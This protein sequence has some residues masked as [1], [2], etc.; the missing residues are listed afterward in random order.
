MLRVTGAGLKY[1]SVNVCVIREPA[2]DTEETPPFLCGD[3]PG[4][5][6]FLVGPDLV[7]MLEPAFVVFLA[8]HGVE[9]K[10]S[11]RSGTTSW[12]GPASRAWL[13][14]LMALDHFRGRM[15]RGTATGC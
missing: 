4:M 7:C 8:A 15:G 13:K 14:R 6:D 5:L 9:S 1:G 10:R 3:K 12:L 11:E 2:L